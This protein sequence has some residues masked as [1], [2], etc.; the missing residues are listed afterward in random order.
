MRVTS[1][2]KVLIVGP[3][4]LTFEVR[5][6]VLLCIRGERVERALPE[7]AVLIE[8]RFDGAEGLGAEDTMVNATVDVS[9]DEARV[10]EHLQV[11]GDSGERHREGRGELGDRLG[12][13]A[14]AGENAPAGRV[15]EGTKYEIE[16]GLDGRARASAR[17]AARGGRSGHDMII[18]TSLNSC[19]AAA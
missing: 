13:A 15:P 1:R 8:P 16:P 6:L 4:C 7:F 12:A 17:A 18:N 3:R 14:Q 2:G 10:L 9:H 5:A 19:K 11:S